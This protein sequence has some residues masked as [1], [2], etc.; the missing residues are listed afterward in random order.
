MLE[1][2]LYPNSVAV[3]G[4]SRTPGKVGYEIAT[5]L[6]DSEFGGDIV[7]VN[8]SGG[9]LH[10]HKVYT[11][12]EEYGKPIEMSVIA[13]PT[14]AVKEAVV[15]SLRAGAKSVV[16][17]TA[18]FREVGEEGARLEEEIA[19][20]CR[21]SGARLMGPNCLGLINTHHNMNASFGRFMPNRGGIS[22]L[23]QSGALCTAILDWAASRK[24]GLATLL[25]I[26]NKADLDEIDFLAAFADDEETKVIMGYLESI[27]SGDEFVRVAETVAAIKPVVILKAGTTSAG[28]KAASSHTGALAGAD[29]AYGA[30][31]KRA[32]VIRAD[33]FESLLDFAMA[34]AMQPL[35]KGDR[36]AIITNAG[37]PGAMAADAVELLTAFGASSLRRRASAI[38]SMSSETPT[39]SATQ[40]RSKRPSRTPKWTP[41]SSSLRPKP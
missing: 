22:V 1:S 39:R 10:G 19:E 15:S 11:A 12:L 27:G 24:M 5:N 26:G 34:L 8:P 13:V 32:G 31:F 3:M 28:S 9:E 14:A 37:G 4:A 29:I 38:P 17:V 2:L 23:S 16:V 20:L 30:A 40:T 21:A 18:G 33:T 6:I 25:S 36:T 41:S 35:P 7:P